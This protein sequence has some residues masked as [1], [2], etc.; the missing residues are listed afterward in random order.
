MSSQGRSA[1]TVF[2]IV[3]AMLSVTTAV[4]L[5]AVALTAASEVAD[6]PL[7][8]FGSKLSL[9]EDADCAT[10]LDTPPDQPFMKCFSEYQ[11]ATQE[12]AALWAREIAARQA[13]IQAKGNLAIIFGLLGVTFAVCGVASGRS[14]RT[15]PHATGTWAA[16]PAPG[17]A[18]APAQAP[19]QP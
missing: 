3:L 15:E 9:F 7:G 4:I 12:D 14:G 17:G 6:E 10:K 19:S 16:D 1:G 18:P 11:A 2:C 5:S 13:D 8:E